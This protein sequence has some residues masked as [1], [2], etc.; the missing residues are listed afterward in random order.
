M[1]RIISN[2]MHRTSSDLHPPLLPA[3]REC[4]PALSHR[5]RPL[6][7][8]ERASPEVP[9]RRLNHHPQVDQQL[10]RKDGNGEPSC[11]S[12]KQQYLM[13]LGTYHSGEEDERSP[14]IHRVGLSTRP[15]AGTEKEY[16]LQVS[17]VNE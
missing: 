16:I 12:S 7:D 10:K 14:E 11:T 6:H 15:T 5:L 17:S 9:Q 3:P 13:D 1:N 2:V 4:L 8:G